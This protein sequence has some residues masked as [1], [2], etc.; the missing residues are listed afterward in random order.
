LIDLHTCAEGRDALGQVNLVGHRIRK[1]DQWDASEQGLGQ[2]AMPKMR[3][4]HGSL[5]HQSPMRQVVANHR[6]RGHAKSRHIDRHSGC[7]DNP[8]RQ[9]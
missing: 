6:V 1:A 7:C 9:L 3:D 4:A 8:D 5:G 2:R